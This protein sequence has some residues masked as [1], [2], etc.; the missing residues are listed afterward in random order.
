MRTTFKGIALSFLAAVV[1]CIVAWQWRFVVPRADDPT[2]LK[3]ALQQSFWP[4]ADWSP[5]FIGLL[6]AIH[7]FVSDEAAVYKIFVSILSFASVLL[8]YTWTRV[9]TN[10]WL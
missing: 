9:V 6:R 2:L 7:F 1:V 10:S 4:S 3:W 5:L 8:L